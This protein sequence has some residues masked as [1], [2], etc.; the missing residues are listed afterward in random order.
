MFL[1]VVP[2]EDEYAIPVPDDL[3]RVPVLGD[4]LPLL[5][6]SNIESSP[7]EA[8]KDVTVSSV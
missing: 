3:S 2:D 5:Y 4:D 8:F 7:T 6:F 1:K